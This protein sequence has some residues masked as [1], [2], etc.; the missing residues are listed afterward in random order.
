MEGVGGAGRGQGGLYQIVITVP[1]CD[2][3]LYGGIS[4]GKPWLSSIYVGE[5]RLQA[6][7]K[8]TVSNGVHGR[9]PRR[10]FAECAGSFPGR[11]IRIT[12]IAIIRRCS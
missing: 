7:G 5:T 11:E 1:D 4:M 3:G 9:D 2:E 8:S 10:R 6:N 12:L